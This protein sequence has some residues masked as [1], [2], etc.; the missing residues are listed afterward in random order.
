MRVHRSLVEQ[1]LERPIEVR[2]SHSDSNC[3]LYYGLG[4]APETM[5]LVVADVALG[6][7]KTARFANRFTGGDLEWSR[8]TP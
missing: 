6:L 1:A 7:V 5:V 3:R 2:H 4:P 8:S